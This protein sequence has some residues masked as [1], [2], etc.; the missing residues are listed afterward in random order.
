MR[1]PCA[2]PDNSPHLFWSARRADRYR[3][4]EKRL[5]HCT[6]PGRLFY[7]SAHR[8]VGNGQALA[9]CGSRGSRGVEAGRYDDGRAAI[10]KRKGEYYYYLQ[11]KI[12]RMTGHHGR[13][14]SDAGSTPAPM[15][16]YRQPIFL[17]RGRRSSHLAPPLSGAASL[18]SRLGPLHW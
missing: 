2:C 5:R 3:R 11:R 14:L 10:L 6:K 16:I 4:G 9:C 15:A 17:C 1:G 7:R 13:D 8:F 12:A 18:M